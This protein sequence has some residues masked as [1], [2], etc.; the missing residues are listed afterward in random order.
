M[1]W[2]FS[3]AHI[4]IPFLNYTFESFMPAL[5]TVFFFLFLFQINSVNKDQMVKKIYSVLLE[6]VVLTPML[7]VVLSVPYLMF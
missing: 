7:D 4:T 2:V 3:S 6:P 5:I 1:K